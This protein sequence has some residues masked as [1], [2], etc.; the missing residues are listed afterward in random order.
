VAGVQADPVDVPRAWAQLA[1][2]RLRGT[3]LVVGAPDVGKSTFSR[4]LYGRLC[5][6]SVRTAF[7]DGDPGQSVLGPPTTMT[8]ALG[9]EGDAVFP[10]KGQTFRSFVGAV[11]PRG[12]ML[13]L[14]AGA[15]RLVQAAYE[16]GAEVVIYDTSGLIDPGRGGLTLKMS[17]VDLLRPSTVFAIQRGH[18]LEPLLVP[19]RRSQRTRVVDLRASVA[20]RRRDTSR[21]QSHR[22]SQFAGYFG[23]ARP[24]EVEWGRMAVLPSPRFSPNRLAALESVDG[25]VLGLGIV[26]D[27]DVSARRVTL[28]TPLPSLDGVDA[29]RLGD[30]VV[31]PE[32]FRDRRLE[33]R[34]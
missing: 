3:L 19:L 8:L 1:V 31:D 4:Y 30:V 16:A 5:A 14:L 25:F 34:H 11:S 6:G 26:L 21:R 12:H 24:V 28:H 32:T 2:E 18:E 23:L 9:Q 20:T 13:P 22:A 17:K 29:L 7:L 33:V 10:P 27:H 15:A